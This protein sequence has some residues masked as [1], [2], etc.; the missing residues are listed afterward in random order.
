MKRIL[1]ACA[2]MAAISLT[3][4]ADAGDFYFGFGSGVRSPISTG[5]RGRLPAYGPH[6]SLYHSHVHRRPSVPSAYW[7]AP[8]ARVQYRTS[9]S[10]RYHSARPS[11]HAAPHAVRRSP[12]SCY[13]Y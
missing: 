12:R 11:W 3:T 9:P 5:Y 1:F 2:A 8:R 13:R 4:T 6:S 10:F 7:A